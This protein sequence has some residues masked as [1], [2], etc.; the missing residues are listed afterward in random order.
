MTVTIAARFNGPPGTANGGYACGVVAEAVGPSASVRLMHPPPL[1]TPLERRRD[2]DGVVRLRAGETTIAEG[3]AARPSIAAPAPPSTAAAALAA[4]GYLGRDPARHPFPTCFVCGPLRPDD[5]LRVFPGPTGADGM[6]AC[7]WR[8]AADLA[9][10]DV[11]DPRFVWAALD[12]PSGLAC[13]PPGSRVVLATMTARLE[14][15]V[16]AGRDYVL[17]A[18][19]IAGEGRKHRAGSALHDADGRRV[20]LAEALWITL[21]SDADTP[22]PR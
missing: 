5:G 11:V 6:L 3:W 16:E 18:W 8:P 12:C 7:T 22:S 9:A 13:M 14:A 21:R 2:D 4:T 10:G 15:P 20:A 19:P 17:S 1:D